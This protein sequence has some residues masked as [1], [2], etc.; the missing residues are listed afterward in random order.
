[1]NE[2]AQVGGQHL[3]RVRIRKGIF[4]RLQD[5]AD[6]QTAACG[7]HVTVS[8]LVQSACFNYLMVYEQLQKLQAAQNQFAAE[9]QDRLDKGDV[10]IIL[11]QA[12]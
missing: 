9:V 10:L 6:E 12:G 11:P 5:V 3:M 7:R 2:K 1:M 4:E 8:D